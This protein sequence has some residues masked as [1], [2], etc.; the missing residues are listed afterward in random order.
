MN[1][2]HLSVPQNR[3][4]VNTP[5]PKAKPSN[6]SAFTIVELLIV[7]VIIAILAAITIIS[8]TG[9]SNRAKNSALSSTLQSGAKKVATYALQNSNTVPTDKAAFL[10]IA[11]YSD[12]NTTTNTPLILLLL[13]TSSVLLLPKTV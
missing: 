2:H 10:T 12:G 4:K 11:G 6:S 7:I 8:Y 13:Q 9:I 3:Q 1:A 5:L